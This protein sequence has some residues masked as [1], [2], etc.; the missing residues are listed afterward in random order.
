M[1]LVRAGAAIAVVWNHCFNMLMMP[2]TPGDGLGYVLLARSASFGRDA[3]MVFFVI[4]G[5]W[6]ARSVT[7]SVAADRW[8]WSNYTINRLSRLY[9]VL[10]PALVLG[11]V[12]DGTGRFLL[13]VAPY[14]A[15]GF[16]Q[17]GFYDVGAHISP[18]ILLGNLVFLQGMAVPPLGSNAPLWTLSREFWYYIWF[19]ALLLAARGRPSWPAL[20]LT[21]ATAILAP[22][23]AALFGCWLLGAGVAWVEPRLT[24]LPFER[25]WVRPAALVAGLGVWSAGTMIARIPGLDY[26][27]GCYSIAASFAVSEF[28]G[29]ASFSLYAYHM[30]VLVM[31][32]AVVCGAQPL[33]LGIP[34]TVFAMVVTLALVFGAVGFA[35][36]TEARTDWLRGLLKGWYVR[37]ALE[38]VAR[39]ERSSASSM[40]D[41]SR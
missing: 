30:P 7:S 40:D 10:I 8:S 28:G 2:V 33:P 12:L 29:K 27:A 4:S 14:R 36:V 9:I 3:V 25:A 18:S 38:T 37:R 41:A 32:I 6:I 16:Q 17:A 22:S 19:P 24:K 15:L 35:S 39:E 23:V 34:S 5:Y 26:Y 11:L 20:A 31:I 13:D 1:D 21:A